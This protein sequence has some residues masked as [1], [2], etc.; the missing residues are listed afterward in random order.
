MRAIQVKQLGAQQPDPF[1]AQAHGLLHVPQR[2]DI[3]ADL[4]SMTVKGASRL[5]RLFEVTLMP[6]VLSVTSGLEL[7]DQGLI[8]VHVQ[9]AIVGIQQHP[10][11]VI[12]GQHGVRHAT[13]RGQ[14]QRTGEDRNMA[15]GAATHGDETGDA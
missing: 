12:Q 15:S 13:Q 7:L 6:L 2:P 4:D 11:A 10:G 1:A 9:F 3:G 8:R 14:A 5:G